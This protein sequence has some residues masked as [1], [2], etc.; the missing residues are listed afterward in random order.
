MCH[1][2]V[3]GPSRHGAPVCGV[4]HY[5]RNSWLR[6]RSLSQRPAG[7]LRARA[8]PFN[9]VLM[10]LHPAPGILLVLLAF[11]PSSHA[12]ERA[13]FVTTL[14]RD[15]V[16]IESFSRSASHLEG[17]IVVRVPGTV[18][19]HYALDLTSSGDVSRS[20]LDVKPLGDTKVPERHVT[21]DFTADSLRIDVDSSG[22]RQ[23]STRAREKG[24]YPQFMTGFGSSYG[25]Y[26][27]LGVYE[28]LIG[29]LG[30]TFD[31]VSIP[32]VNMATGRKV[33]RDF[34]RRS[35]TLVDAD[36]F[37]IAWTHLT[38]DASGQITSADASET[39]E[40][41]QSLRTDFID[42]PQAAKR[43]VAADK[44]GNGIGTAS[45]SAVAKGTVGGQQIVVTYSSPRRRNRSILGTV[46]PYDQVWRTG[47][48]E[49]TLLFTDH[50][51]E[52]GGT[53]IPAGTY[54]LWTVPKRDGSVQL[55]V[56]GQHGQWG[57]DYDASHDVAHVPMKV[58]TA[59]TPKDDF[60][61]AIAD[62]DGGGELRIAWDTFVWTVPIRVK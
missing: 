37:R 16:A 51:L 30:A 24:A 2:H 10:H 9:F 3:A 49:A 19:C 6:P 28:A 22:H 29:H 27:S 60:T 54:S 7:A 14:G 39:T 59:A 58:T 26:S 46:V 4:S 13:A 62:S 45:P 50:A 32:S 25:L 11:Q 42:V 57:T 55:I 36:Y 44:S 20:V 21:I 41:T 34:V 18:L 35:P 12:D 43:F 40:K 48:N 52:I 56:N 53:P 47:A 1:Y 17:D 15:T 23:K 33:M 5:G 61:M 8:A 38:L 31:S